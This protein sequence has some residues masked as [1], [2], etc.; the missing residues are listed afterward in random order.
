MAR[1][2]EHSRALP[3][4]LVL[5]LT[6]AGMGMYWGGCFDTPALAGPRAD[7]WD[8]LKAPPVTPAM[9]E[10]GQ[11]VYQ[12]NCAAC[13]GAKGKA[14]GEAAYLL[15]PKPRDL[16]RGNQR[17]ISSENGV[18]RVEDLFLSITRGMPGSSMPPWD[19]LPEA[20]RW[21]VAH[22]AKSL[23]PKD[24][25]APRT[26]QPGPEPALNENS[27]ARGRQLFLSSCAAC[28]GA[29]GRGDGQQQQFDE[30]NF[31]IRPRDLTRGLF[32]GSGESYDLYCR[33]RAGMPGSPMPAAQ[34][35]S[36]EDTWHLVHFIQSL[37][38]P[39]AE[40]RNRQAFKALVAR[41][42]GEAWLQ[43]PAAAAWQKIPGQYLA[44]MPMA[45]RDERPEGLI[46]RAAYDDQDLAVHLTWEDATHSDEQVHT[47]SF[48]DGAAVQI[49]GEA[50]PPLFAM[51][52]KGAPDLRV[53]FWK[54]AFEKDREAGFQDVQ[55]GNPN[56]Y[57]AHYQ[58]MQ[59]GPTTP[60]EP[61]QAPLDEH[62]ATFLTGRGAGNQTAQP[63]P[64]GAESLTAHGIGTLARRPASDAGVRARGVWQRGFYSL[65][66]RRPL[67]QDGDKALQLA[68]G[69]KFSI[70]FAIWD[71]AAG[72][73]NGQK[74]VTIW[75]TLEL[76]K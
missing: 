24:D 59:D 67:K 39:G 51:G 49:S 2:P 37:S 60:K 12:A 36:S 28:H 29:S 33:I 70:A 31:P 3:S 54:A 4:I 76:A 43:D 17:L 22:Y 19:R 6:G 61:K 34:H 55:H 44:V 1:E 21:A 14:D 32:K 63:K 74:S 53:W 48:S 27:L 64:D 45:W 58:H 26:I 18:A 30:L 38:G 23:G 11:Q 7:G 46:V 75:H 57:V 9:L 65:V 66:F 69:S 20:D 68:A 52:A 72:D 25:E 42:A 15:V 56:M 73:R 16:T 71:G 5:L 13:H 8:K 62:N 35:L 47:A 41:K 40:L 50:D 10:R